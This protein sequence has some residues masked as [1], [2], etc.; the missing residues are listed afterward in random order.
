MA[1]EEREK[2]GK[3]Q[4]P[5]RREKTVSTG[6]VVF[7]VHLDFWPFTVRGEYPA[8]KETHDHLNE[9]ATAARP[10]RRHQTQKS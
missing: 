8:D 1:F 10:T 3:R 9:T 4:R 2:K 6:A 5:A 7:G